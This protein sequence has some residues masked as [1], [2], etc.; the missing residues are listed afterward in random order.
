MR[1]SMKAVVRRSKTSKLDQCENSVD[2]KASILSTVYC[3]LFTVFRCFLVTSHCWIEDVQPGP[4]Q[5]SF[6]HQAFILSFLFSLQVLPG[7]HIVRYSLFSIFLS[8]DIAV[9][10]Y[11][12]L[13]YC[14][15]FFFL[16]NVFQIAVRFYQVF[17][18]LAF[19]RFFFLRLHCETARITDFHL[20]LY[21]K[22]FE[23]NLMAL[24][25]KCQHREFFP[26]MS[27]IIS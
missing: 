23:F 15:L 18:L 24:C 26:A 11:K 1:S 21:R 2:H 7:F 14:R 12:T 6:D 25:Q 8:L 10:F 9:K 13:I 27:N 5:K 17:I 22:T 16:T 19:L 3:L 20:G 4:R